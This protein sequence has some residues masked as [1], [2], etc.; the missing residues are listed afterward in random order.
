MKK[1][2]SLVLLG[3]AFL[4]S[5]CNEKETA[6]LKFSQPKESAVQSQ[7]G[8]TF[9]ALMPKRTV[10]F[11]QSK[12]LKFTPDKKDE[13]A[14]T[15]AT[16]ETFADLQETGFD[17]L[18]K[19]LLQETYSYL[20]SEN[21]P[22]SDNPSKEDIV[23]L[24][25]ESHQ[26]DIQELKNEPGLGMAFR[27]QSDYIGQRKN[28]VTFS[29]E[30][31]TYSGGAHGMHYTL[32]INIDT[33]KKAVLRLEDILPKDKQEKAAEL[34]WR[35][36][37]YEIMAQQQPFTPKTDFYIS[38]QFYFNQNGINF[39]YPPY[40]LNAYAYGNVTLVLPWY[41]AEDIINPTYQWED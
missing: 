13:Y 16:V 25:Q 11:D 4:L 36:Y 19:L 2:L 3:S 34:L 18:D 33:D 5:A 30:L 32:Y 31:S 23:N 37:E 14:I 22:K 29:N 1:T 38:K 21:T 27:I 6:G 39:V 40:A 41:E 9:P 10:L 17:W 20:L 15:Q 35:Y 8:S 7:Q 12:Q 28:I 26:S 24:L